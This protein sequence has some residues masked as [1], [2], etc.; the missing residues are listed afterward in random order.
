VNVVIAVNEW[1]VSV[2]AMSVVLSKAMAKTEK[3]EKYVSWSFVK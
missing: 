1:L 2:C 3:S